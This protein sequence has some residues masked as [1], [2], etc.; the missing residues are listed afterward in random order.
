MSAPLLPFTL[1]GFDVGLIETSDTLLQVDASSHARSACCPDCDRRSARIHS[2][3]WRSLRDLPVSER[4]VRLRLQIPRFFCDTPT[5]PRRTFAERLPDLAPVRAQRTTRLTHTL[6]TL[7]VALGGEAGARLAGHV[8][9]PTSGDTLVRIMRTS[10]A[11]VRPIPRVLGVDDFAFRKGRTYGTLLVDLEQRCPVDLLPDRTAGTLT[12]WLQQHPGVEIIARDRALDYVRGATAGAPDAIQVADRF[13]LLCNMRETVERYFI[14]VRPALRRS[15]APPTPSDAPDVLPSEEARTVQRRYQPSLGVRQLQAVRHAER[16]ERYGHIKQR[17]AQ[18]VS[19]RQI[20]HETGLCTTTISR[21]LRTDALP[22]ERR[23]YRATG[24]IDPF[25]PYL[26]SRLADGCTNQ[27]RLW[28]ELREQGFTGTRS[29][30]GKWVRLHGHDSRRGQHAG[31][32]KLPS[33]KHLSWLVVQPDAEQTADNQAVWE[34]LKDH[35]DLTKVHAIAQQFVA[36]VRQRHAE[37]LDT[38]FSAARASGVQELRTFAEVLH[39]D[40]AAVKAALTLPWSTGPVEGQINRL[41]FIK[42]SAYGRMK[43]DL[44]RQRVL[45]AA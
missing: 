35:A 43:V 15:L 14:R 29:L 5:C 7:G 19:M 6:R 2:R 9:M 45:H 27:S 32:P 25:V 3:Y 1:P 13:H 12:T 30:M 20:A 36:L 23:G 38:W 37:P 17:F 22:P 26:Y 40:Y 16:A 41:K 42:R 31:V 4:T 34:Q 21:W 24:K 39:R 28:R 8:R 11:P 10:P 44:L 18:G 33:A